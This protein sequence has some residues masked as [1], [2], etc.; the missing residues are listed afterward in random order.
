MSSG[1]QG[2]GR[3]ACDARGN[4]LPE[5]RDGLDL[6]LALALVDPIPLMLRPPPPLYA[7]R[8]IPLN[9]P[10]QPGTSRS[11]TRSCYPP[12]STS[13]LRPEADVCRVFLLPEVGRKLI[14][15]LDTDVE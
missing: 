11:A 2:D 8:S 7:G 10:G 9:A 15:Q 12:Q 14:I 6:A 5:Q 4:R 3:A 1:I 13:R